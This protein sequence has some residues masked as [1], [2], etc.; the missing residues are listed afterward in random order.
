MKLFQLRV[1]RS[2][3]SQGLTDSYDKHSHYFRN[4]DDCVFLFYLLWYLIDTF[5]PLSCKKLMGYCHH[6]AGQ[7][8][9]EFV[10][11]INQEGPIHYIGAATNNLGCVQSSVTL[12]SRYRAEVIFW[13]DCA[14]TATQPPLQIR[15]LVFKKCI[16][17]HVITFQICKLC[18]P[19]GFI[20][21]YSLNIYVR[22]S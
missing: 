4:A 17:K 3:S 1:K 14:H 10:N 19:W 2:I 12:T 22:P 16:E 6:P 8:D 15:W 18:F 9:G 7:A 5:L 13:G 21:E 20:S 11:V